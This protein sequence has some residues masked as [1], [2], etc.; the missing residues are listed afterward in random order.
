MNVGFGIVRRTRTAFSG[1]VFCCVLAS[2][3][4]A[5]VGAVGAEDGQGAARP[6]ARDVGLR[7]GV[8]P[9][10]ENNAITDVA[11]VRVGHKT[12]VQGESIRTG[13]TVIVPHEGDVFQSK[14]PAAVI[15]G[16]GFGKLVGSTQV[17]ELGVIETPIALTN[18]LSVFVAADAL[19]KHT[20]SQP[21]NESVRSVNPVAAETN[22]GYLNDIRGQHVTADDVLAA[23]RAARG[24]TVAEGS[25]GAGTGTRCF[26]YKGGIGT[27][28]RQIRNGDARYHLGVLVQSNFG[29]HLTIQGIP[30]DALGEPST[31]DQ[32]G[33]ATKHEDG[34]CVVVIATDAPLDARQLERIGRRALLGIGATGSPISHGSGDYVIVFSTTADLRVEFGKTLRPGHRLADAELTPWFQA[35]RE[36]TEEAII[37]SMF[38]ATSVTGHEGRRTRAIDIPRVV[39]ILGSHGV[40]QE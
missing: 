21:G 36:A 1:R 31:G 38:R 14:V 39:E 23:I 11:G 17:D 29:G 25:V 19:V 27:S 12:V 3:A 8:L 4:V 26:G 22:D 24:G 18:T 32:T 33:A 6:R 16:N 7:F 10:G 34:S 15:V 30:M 2:A 9:T 20:L 28:S 37:N 13:V 35:A 40:L 5:L